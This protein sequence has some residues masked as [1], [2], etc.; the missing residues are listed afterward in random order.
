MQ[1]AVERL[2]RLVASG[3]HSAA[4]DLEVGAE[5]ALSG[6]VEPYHLAHAVKA[7]GERGELIEF[8]LRK[9]TGCDA[10]LNAQALDL[11]AVA[12]PHAGE[13]FEARAGEEAP[14]R[15][16]CAPSPPDS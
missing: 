9:R 14:D 5:Q 11:L 7:T 10:S 15:K 1:G 16:D 4:D 8:A 2:G 12:N 3:D 13:P 6:G